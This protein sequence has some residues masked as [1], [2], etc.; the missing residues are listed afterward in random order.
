MIHRAKAFKFPAFRNRKNNKEVSSESLDIK[1]LLC[2]IWTRSVIGLVLIAILS[3]T[4]FF[5][6]T[7]LLQ[8][9]EKNG[10]IVNISGRQRML[11]QR[12][13]FFALELATTQNTEKRIEA[14]KKLNS[15]AEV[16]EISH[17]GL[18]NGSVELDLPEKRSDAINTIYFEAPDNLDKQV[19]QYIDAIRKL[20]S[21]AEKAQIDLDNE[22]LQ[23][24]LET[25]PTRLLQTLN[26]AVL[27]YEREGKSDL[28][29]ALLYEKIIYYIVLLTLLL[30]VLFIYRPLVNRVRKTTQDFLRQKHFSDS[31]VDTSKALIIGTDQGGQVRLFNHYSEQLTGWTDEEIHGKNF[32]NTFIPEIEKAKITRNHEE[33]FAGRHAGKLE[34]TLITKTGDELAIEWS[35]TPLIDPQTKKITLLLSTGIDITQRKHDNESLI[36]ALG[37]TA[38]LSSRLKK[39]VGHAAALQ[40]ALL[41]S[42]KFVL[43]G[44][45]GLAQLTTSAEVGGDYYDYY[46]VDGCHSVFLVGDVGGKGV[47]AGMLLSAAKMAIHQLDNMGETDPAVILRYINQLLINASHESML[48][49]MVCFSLDSRSGVT[50]MASAGHVPPYHW[51]N[52]KREWRSLEA[53]GLPLCKE[54][55]AEYQCISLDLEV[56][57]KLF[58]YTDGILD[59]ELPNGEP[60]GVDRLEELL[61]GA[62]VLP[63][64]VANTVIFGG[65]ETHTE[66]TVFSDDVMLMMVAHTERVDPEDN[67]VIDLSTPK[68]L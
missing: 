63:I 11:S 27:Q 33:L 17:L 47:A 32:I 7:N 66:K 12:G 40:Q 44:I 13:A 67:A 6:L 23:Y 51:T 24:I 20:L 19:N 15:V 48:M 28:K 37:E 30:E 35:N 58:L 36:M 21:D 16:M 1:F 8:L 4:T 68:H 34:T 26:K 22:N 55:N 64:E 60:F 61:Y 31:V 39:E 25:A 41:P 59:E 18:I 42:P 53:T 52:S 45:Q 14:S 54:A 49:S 50:R 65:L 9:S 57:D 2:G 38:S 10:S 43:P 5:I 56:G 29:S 46:Q 62:A 3:T